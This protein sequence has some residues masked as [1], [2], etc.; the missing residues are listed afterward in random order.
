MSFNSLSSKAEAECR[1]SGE[2]EN[3]SD[4]ATLVS[5]TDPD[6][7]E[8]EPIEFPSSQAPAGM[9]SVE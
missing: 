4:H 2:R 8:E 3:S 9:S 7:I 6:E 5:P 1:L